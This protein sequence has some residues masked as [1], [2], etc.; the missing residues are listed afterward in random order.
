ML[1]FVTERDDRQ[2]RRMNLHLPNTNTSSMNPLIASDASLIL[3]LT[4][5]AGIFLTVSAT[6]MIWETGSANSRHMNII[7]Y[8]MRQKPPSQHPASSRCRKISNEADAGDEEDEDVSVD[9]K[10]SVRVVYGGGR[11][12]ADE[13]GD[14]T[15]RPEDDVQHVDRNKNPVRHPR[16]SSPHHSGYFLEKQAKRDYQDV[17]M[18]SLHNQRAYRCGVTIAG[19]R[20]REMEAD[21]RG[22]T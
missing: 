5:S 15:P 6:L 17:P 4:V 14:E 2:K 10:V 20:N 19:E 13:P 8:P 3:G 16:K 12:G 22:L 11:E 21:M 9:V 7:N 1:N 18:Y